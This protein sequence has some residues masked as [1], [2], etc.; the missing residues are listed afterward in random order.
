MSQEN[1]PADALIEECKIQNISCLY[2]STSLYIWLRQKKYIRNVFIVAPI[3]LGTFATWSILDQPTIEWLQWATATFAMLAG[4]FPVIYEALNMDADIL[5]IQKQAATYK[6][7]QDRFR[8]LETVA[9][10]QPYDE[11]SSAFEEVM[12]QMEKIRGESITPPERCFKAA[13]KKIDSGDYDF[14]IG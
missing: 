3:I 1:T 14:N 10:K 8:Q 2:T 13:Q 7:L 11:F 4:L 12:S 9:S 5:D 6:N